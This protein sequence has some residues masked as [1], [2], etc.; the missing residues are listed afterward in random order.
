MLISGHQL[1]HSYCVSHYITLLPQLRLLKSGAT[2]LTPLLLGRLIR[3]VTMTDVESDV[4]SDTV[5]VS[6]NFFRKHRQPWS[7]LE[8]EKH[9][10]VLLIYQETQSQK[11]QSNS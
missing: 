9:Q 2:H 6:C 5:N 1:S 10:N 11:K 8:A 7:V 3:A 4:Y